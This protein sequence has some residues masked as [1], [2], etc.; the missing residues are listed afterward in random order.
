MA[1]GSGNGYYERPLGSPPERGLDPYNLHEWI[2]WMLK[3]H[4]V[5]V[6]QAVDL[7]ITH[8]ICEARRQELEDATRSLQFLRSQYAEFKTHVVYF[9]R[10]GSHVKVG[11]TNDIA[12]RMRT[13]KTPSGGAKAPDGLVTKKGELLGT[14]FGYSKTEGILHRMLAEHR[15]AGEWFDWNQDTQEIIEWAISRGRGWEDLKRGSTAINMA[16]VYKQFEERE[17]A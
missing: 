9:F 2:T 5:D 17:S 4:G 3:Q 8:Q 12:A 6:T 10:V 1:G 13:L 14:I 15:T 7:I 11:K 16:R